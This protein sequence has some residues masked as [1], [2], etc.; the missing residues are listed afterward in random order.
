MTTDFSNVLA[1][2]L[3]ENK[4][5]P[6]KTVVRNLE[7]A[8]EQFATLLHPLK[9]GAA[10]EDLLA[11]FRASVLNS[12]TQ[13][14]SVS[15]LSEAETRPFPSVPVPPEIL[16]WALEQHNEQEIAE[17]LREV[18]ATGG[19]QLRDFIQELEQAAGTRD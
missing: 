5:T 3:A 13:M 9:D 11:R 7:A 12:L 14:E 18:R 17:G 10:R 1:R 6:E 2:F 15:H 8:C 19:L 4:L 16:A